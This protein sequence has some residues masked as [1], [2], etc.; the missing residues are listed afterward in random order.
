MHQ[1]HQRGIALHTSIL[2][3][4]GTQKGRAAAS[5]DAIRR[6]REKMSKIVQKDRDVARY[7][8]LM[9]MLKT[10]GTY[11]TI[12]PELKAVRATLRKKYGEG[13]GFF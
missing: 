2:K 9:K 8:Q 3:S 5:A 12:G 1:R 7:F 4:R 10:R 6:K 13:T 11:K